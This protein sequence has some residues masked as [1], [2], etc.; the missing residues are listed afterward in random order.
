MSDALA[1]TAPPLP[2]GPPVANARRQRHSISVARPGRRRYRSLKID[3]SVL[4]VKHLPSGFT[5]DDLI[6]LCH[7][8]GQIKSAKLLT[9]Q[10][11]HEDL[12]KGVVK[13]VSTFAAH[14]ALAALDGKAVGDCRL[15]VSRSD[16]DNV[17]ERAS[18]KVLVKKIPN[19]VD[20]AC[21]R[22][23]FQRFGDIASLVVL[24]RESEDTWICTIK[25][26]T[27]EAATAAKAGMNKKTLAPETAPISVKFTRAKVAGELHKPAVLPAFR[28]R[29]MRLREISLPNF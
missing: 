9:D 25:Y 23:V 29:S 28:R 3:E 2:P 20:E 26:T 1:H 13:F 19:E 5:Q 15:A 12:H 24:D 8:F 21:V 7:P 22:K 27:F 10:E 11:T 18:L 6:Q 16:V 4:Y 14:A 17:M